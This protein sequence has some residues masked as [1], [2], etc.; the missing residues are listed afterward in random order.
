MLFRARARR[1]CR[2]AMCR[3][4]TLIVSML[5]TPELAQADALHHVLILYPYDNGLPAT[6][7]PGE[8]IRRYLAEV[9]KGSIVVHPAFLDLV[10]F[11]SSQDMQRTADFLAEKAQ[12]TPFDIVVALNTESLRFALQHRNTFA[13][14]VPL[15]FCCVTRAIIN[16]I[17]ALP[18]DV[19][20]VISEY[21]MSRTLDLALKLQPDIKHVYF[22]SGSSP[23]DDRWLKSY[24]PQLDPYAQKYDLEYLVGLPFDELLAKVAT[25]PPHSVI[26][27][28]T[29]F[30]DGSG[31]QLIPVE[32]TE[33]V[34][35]AANAP[36]YVPAEPYLGRGPI[37]GYMSTFEAAG[38]DAAALVVKILAGTKPTDLP[39]K[40]VSGLFY[41]VDARALKRWGIKQSDLPVGT[42]LLFGTPSLWQQHQAE[43]ITAISIIVVQGGLLVALI[44]Q[45]RRRRRAEQANQSAQTELARVTRRTTMGE[46]TASIA[47]EVNQPLAAIVASGSAALRW[48]DRPEPEIGE[49]RDALKN[50]T[51]EGHRAADVIKSIRAL[52]GNHQGARS[53]FDLEALLR[54]VLMLTRGEMEAQGVTLRT[55]IATSSPKVAGDRVQIQQVVLNLVI[56]AIE[57]MQ[58]V[59]RSNR[60][61]TVSLSGSA[62]DSVQIRIA[63]TGSGISIENPNRVFESFFTTKSNGMGMG[64]SI[65]RSILAAHGGSLEIEKTNERGTTFLVNIPSAKQDNDSQS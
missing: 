27:S 26:L 63:D 14:G 33:A 32:A 31:R 64:L 17:G 50:I 30:Q 29:L 2:P 23:V 45:S 21:D 52:L 37:G 55:R 11:P 60:V 49:A 39:T 13:P 7:I 34:S 57:A 42:K 62:P 12:V 48:L 10:Q 41:M 9:G 59:Q 22:I 46:M 20:G 1:A 38:G 58:S 53:H 18:P 47:H 51:R 56:N 61:L 43:V 15:V 4:V 40:S 5:V 65:C 8:A 35:K 3:I 19:T 16:E 54:D 36:V 44:V 24:K 28:G 25:L 6:N